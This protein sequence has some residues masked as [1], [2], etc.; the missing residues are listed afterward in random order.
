MGDNRGLVAE[1]TLDEKIQLLHGAPDPAGKATGYLPGIDR[2]DIPPLRLVD[3]PM[4]V[5][6]GD[7]CATAFPAPICLAA[8]WD[9][10][11]ARTFGHALG[12]E[13]A[14]LG[15]D[16]VL[17]PGVNI[18]RVPHG[19]RNFEYYSEDSLLT[20]RIAVETIE[21][22]Q[23]TGVSAT[24]KHSSQTTRKRTGTERVPR[25]ASGRSERSTSRPSG[26]ASSRPMCRA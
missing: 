21:G 4:G 20:S 24:V 9:P 26:P 17:G 10:D 19:G 25:S 6:A 16:M 3:G 22:I 15:Q 18:I 5:R 7:E 14:T 11:L 8:S 1:L 23:S 12:R 2:L 13:A